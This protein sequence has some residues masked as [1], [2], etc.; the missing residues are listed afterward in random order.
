MSNVASTSMYHKFN[1][2]I[3]FILSNTYKIFDVLLPSLY[4]FDIVLKIVLMTFLISDDLY[5]QDIG[6]LLFEI[7]V[8]HNTCLHYN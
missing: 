3:Y 7:S 2:Q 6:Q 4:I 8:R 5:F 1:N